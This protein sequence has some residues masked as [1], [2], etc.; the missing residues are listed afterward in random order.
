MIDSLL[1]VD[2]ATA[3]KAVAVQPDPV[4]VQQVIEAL[5]A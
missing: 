1:P 2:T 3:L 4:S 5:G